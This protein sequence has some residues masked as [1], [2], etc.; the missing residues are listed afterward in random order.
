MFVTAGVTF[1]LGFLVYALGSNNQSG[2][3]RSVRWFVPLG[4]P[5]WYVSAPLVCGG[6]GKFCVFVSSIGVGL[7]VAA[8]GAALGPWNGDVLPGYWVVVVVLVG[9][10]VYSLC[11]TQKERKLNLSNADSKPG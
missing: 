9:L 11:Q 1:A 7:W 2:L 3:C 6:G 8:W 5:L 10:G 4:I